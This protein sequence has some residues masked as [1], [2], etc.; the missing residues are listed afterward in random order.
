MRGKDVREAL[1]HLG[2]SECVALM[3]PQALGNGRLH[4]QL[5]AWTEGGETQHAELQLSLLVDDRNQPE[6]YLLLAR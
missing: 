6:G 3:T 5:L 1:S 4:T 2:W